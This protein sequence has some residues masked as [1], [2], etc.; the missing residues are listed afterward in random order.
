MERENPMWTIMN[1]SRELF[2]KGCGSDGGPF[3]HHFDCAC[4][5]SVPW[6]F[7]N[8]GWSEHSCVDVAIESFDQMW[9]LSRWKAIAAFPTWILLIA[10]PRLWMDLIKIV[11]SI[12]MCVNVQTIDTLP[13]CRGENSTNWSFIIERGPLSN[14]VK[15]IE[16]GFIWYIEKDVILSKAPMRNMLN[17]TLW[18]QD[19]IR[20]ASMCIQSWSVCKKSVYLRWPH[21]W[22]G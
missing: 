21:R 12:S 1:A 4:H 16:K 2:Q 20:N 11:W 8:A 15:S 9:L 5:H 13:P 18:L 3:Y 7:S 22:D 6:N 17:N 19:W 14:K 10:P